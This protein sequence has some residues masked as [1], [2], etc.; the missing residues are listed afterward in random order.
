MA[1]FTE[2]QLINF[3]KPASNTEEQ[4][5]EYAKKAIK[6]AIDKDLKLS[7]KSIEI[8]GQGSYANDTNVKNNS[9]VDINV[10]Y[11]GGFYYKIPP[12]TKKED[13]GLVNPSSYSF[14]E[15][16]NDVEQ[17]LLNNFKGYKVNRKN[18]CIS[19]NIYG[20]DVDV[21]P[22]W[23][24]RI[25]SLNGNSVESVEGVTLFTNNTNQQ[26]INYPKQ[27]IE[28]G[29]NKNSDT[30]KR[31][32]WLT[33]IYKKIR[34]KMIDDGVIISN[35]ITSFLLE[36][37][38]WNVPNH[39]FNNRDTWTERLQ[40]S[41]KHLYNE[42]KNDKCKDWREVSELLYL[43]HNDRKWSKQDVLDYLEQMWDYLEY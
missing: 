18:K 5:L 35:N 34:Y 17:A 42:I 38:V 13:F 37:L 2:V 22:T 29:K 4:K 30:H 1:K 15:F 32:K 36:C 23:V 8:F 12:N 24:H 31:F 39:I 26:I 9:D 6:E 43:F 16:K 33:R 20:I 21:V 7:Q 3:S 27:H 14:K 25:F 10:M 28:N 11:K 41:M 40:E 19:I